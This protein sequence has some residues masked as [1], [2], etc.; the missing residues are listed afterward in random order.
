VNPFNVNGKTSIG[1]KQ[2]STVMA[3]RREECVKEIHLKTSNLKK[4]SC[5]QGGKEKSSRFALGVEKYF[6]IAQRLYNSL[7]D[8]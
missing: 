4:N 8:F 1:L 2:H 5:G 3:T 7:T 6:P